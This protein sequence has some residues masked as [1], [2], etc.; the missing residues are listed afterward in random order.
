M[1]IGRSF[2]DFVHPKDRETFSNQITNGI[3]IPLADCKKDKFKGNATTIMINM[4]VFAI[5]ICRCKTF[6]TCLLKEI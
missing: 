6:Y 1:W 2:I 5:Q 3:Y 4:Y